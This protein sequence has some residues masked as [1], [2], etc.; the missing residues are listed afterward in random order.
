[1]GFADGMMRAEHR[2]LHEAEIGFRRVDVSKTAEPHIFV[3]RM[4][5]RRVSGKFAPICL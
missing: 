4:V 5:D 1:M 3:G 2:A